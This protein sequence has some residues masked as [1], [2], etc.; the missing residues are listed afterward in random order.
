MGLVTDRL[1]VVV[2]HI[3]VAKAAAE[4]PRLECTSAAVATVGLTMDWRVAVAVAGL[5]TDWSD[6]VVVFAASAGLGWSAEKRAVALVQA[7]CSKLADSEMH[8][9]ARV[10]VVLVEVAGTDST[11]SKWAGRSVIAGAMVLAE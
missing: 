7:L 6:T 5:A 4:M 10:A 9:R 3:V 2:L 8:S 11:S 1:V